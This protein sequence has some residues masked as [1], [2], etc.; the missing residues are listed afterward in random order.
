MLPFESIWWGLTTVPPSLIIQCFGWWEN[1]KFNRIY[2]RLMG[3]FNALPRIILCTS[4]FFLLTIKSRKTAKYRKFT[5]EINY[6]CNCRLHS[7]ATFR[8]QHQPNLLFITGN[9]FKYLFFIFHNELEKIFTVAC[10]IS[11]NICV[12]V[13]KKFV[14]IYWLEFEWISR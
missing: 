7:A 8:K 6:D 14:D 13:I 2:W 10:K 4:N 11:K 3:I 12:N 1:Y 5:Q 9:I